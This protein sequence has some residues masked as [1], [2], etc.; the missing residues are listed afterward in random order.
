MFPFGDVFVLFFFFFSADPD[1]QL[2]DMG[3]TPEEESPPCPDEFDDFVTFE[4][5]ISTVNSCKCQLCAV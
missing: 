2:Y 1:S 4:V 3:Y 5:S